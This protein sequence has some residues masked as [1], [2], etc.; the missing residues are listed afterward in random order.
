M[1]ILK[2]KFLNLLFYLFLILYFFSG[3]VHSQSESTANARIVSNSYSAVKD[4]V[5]QIGVL[6]DLAKDWHIYWK[7][8]G[9][10][11][12]PTSIEWN[13]PNEFQ[14]TQEHMAYS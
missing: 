13:I 3:Q 14:F 1:S 12:M 5:I 9:D 10:S 8:P 6:I 2:F 7:N 4:S 11:G